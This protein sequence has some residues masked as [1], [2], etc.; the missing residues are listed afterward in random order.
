ML[1]GS[2][3]NHEPTAMNFKKTSSTFHYIIH[4]LPGCLLECNVSEGTYRA[5]CKQR[6][7][8]GPE[9]FRL[10]TSLAAM[11]VL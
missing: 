4:L 5:S 6:C 1:P 9:D 3:A 10:E 7:G 2:G 11:G 8:L